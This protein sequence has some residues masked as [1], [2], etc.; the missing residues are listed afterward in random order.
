MVVRLNTGPGRPP[1]PSVAGVLYPSSDLWAAGSQWPAQSQ[2]WLSVDSGRAPAAPGLT[3]VIQISSNAKMGKQCSLN[4][5]N[6]I[7]TT[8]SALKPR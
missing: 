6:K 8:S 3:L 7:Y 1:P 5:N 4:G 2:S